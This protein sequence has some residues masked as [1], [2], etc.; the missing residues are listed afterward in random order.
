M[1]CPICDYFC[2]SVDDVDHRQEWGRVEYYCPRCENYLSRKVT[3]KPQ[4]SMVASDVW[5]NEDTFEDLRDAF[6]NRVPRGALQK[7]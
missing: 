1:R 5:E 6:E 2:L 7:G 4:S 3:Y